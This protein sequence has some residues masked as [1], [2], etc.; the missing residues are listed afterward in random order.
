MRLTSFQLCRYLTNNCLPLG[1]N[2]KRSLSSF[3]FD[4]WKMENCI[5][6]TSDSLC[7]KEAKNGVCSKRKG[8]RRRK[9]R[10]QNPRSVGQLTICPAPTRRKEGTMNFNM[11]EIKLMGII[12]GE[13]GKFNGE[14]E[15]EREREEADWGPRGSR[16]L[17]VH[18]GSI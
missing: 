6:T 3:L 7:G 1:K 18:T 15:E 16:L 5:K 10:K 4:S 9:G 17:F 11:P 2:E 14:E 8:R 12:Y 13:T